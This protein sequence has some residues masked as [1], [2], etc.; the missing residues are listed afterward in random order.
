MLRPSRAWTVESLL[1]ADLD[2]DVHAGGC[3]VRGGPEGVDPDGELLVRS[4]VVRHLE[5][6]DVA[7]STGRIV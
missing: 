6:V 5:V 2:N 4:G 7:P 1:L 3:V